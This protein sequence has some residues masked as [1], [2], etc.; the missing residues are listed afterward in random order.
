MKKTMMIL[1]AICSMF[2]MVPDNIYAHPGRTN[3]S[4]CHVCKNNC[5]SWGLSNGEYHCHGGNS[6]SSSGNSASTNNSSNSSRTNSNPPV[7]RKSSNAN[8]S[9]LKI[10]G[11]NISISDTMNFTT[12]NA[13][14]NIEGITVDSKATLRIDKPEQLSR[15]LLNEITITV[16][17]EDSTTKVYKLFISLVSND[18]T[19]KRLK[20]GK[21]EIKIND[22][23]NF[24]TTDSK[25]KINATTNDK[26]AKIVSDKEYKLNIG[27]NK[28]SIKTLAEDGITE[29]EYILNVKRKRILSDNVGIIIT[30]NG[31]KVKFNN[32][33]S[34]KIYISSGINELDI[35]YKLEDKKA[36][37][38]LKYD[39][40]INTGDKNI[41]FKVIAENGKEQ[42]YIL[43]FYKYSKTEEIIYDIIAW[44]LI[45]LMGYGSYKL[46]KKI[47]DKR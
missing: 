32:Y 13:M 26:K 35:K 8:L 3:G 27:D 5:A 45:G 42:E 46:F 25:I 10:D 24:T 29:K 28:I 38:D 39:K 44:A 16:S 43:N 11:E 40:K 4:G 21:K 30:V 33:K 9:I 37:I 41:K 34:E 2:L 20:I 7:Y 22:E 17:A 14:P 12:T 19:I 1:F 23:M 18:A 15:D 6:Y 47:K 36:N 31:E